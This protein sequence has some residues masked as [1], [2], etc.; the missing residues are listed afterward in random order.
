L[1]VGSFGVYWR[2]ASKRALLF[3]VMGL[4]IP[5]AGKLG[6]SRAFFVPATREVSVFQTV[7]IGFR[8][9]FPELYM[10]SIIC[11]NNKSVKRIL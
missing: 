8:R 4:C 5:K 9:L 6:G 10:A 11:Y 2:S 7:S 3:G 1:K